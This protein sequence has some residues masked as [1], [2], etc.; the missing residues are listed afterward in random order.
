MALFEHCLC[1]AQLLIAIGSA[2]DSTAADICVHEEAETG[3][4]CIPAC[5]T[6]TTC[7]NDLCPPLGSGHVDICGLYAKNQTSEFANLR[8][9]SVGLDC[10]GISQHSI[11]ICSSVL[12]KIGSMSPH[13]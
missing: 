1:L 12:C 10:R 6:N 4:A 5:V 11:D 9:I 3:V 2:F 8:V 13:A 7:L